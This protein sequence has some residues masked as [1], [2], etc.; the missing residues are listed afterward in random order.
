MG[1]KCFCH[2]N[3]LEVKDAK[4]RNAAITPQMFGYKSGDL[5]DYLLA[6][7][8]S[9]LTVHVPNGD[10]TITKEIQVPEAQEIIFDSNANV[11]L[12]G[13]GKFVLDRAS[14]LQGGR[15]LGSEVP[16]VMEMRSTTKW[17]QQA[18]IL[19][20]YIHG[21]KE[22]TNAIVINTTAPYV[23]ACYCVVD[24]VHISG[25][26]YGVIT[27]TGEWSNNHKIDVYCAET[28]TAIDLAGSG[29]MV[30]VA[31]Q[32]PTTE[33]V[34]VI[35]SGENNMVEVAIYDIRSAQYAVELTETSRY[36]IVTEFGYW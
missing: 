4:A 28:T 3:G 36:N 11:T 2:L 23:A 35:I 13:S 34:P 6:A 5:S 21:D 17:M 29:C 10:Y 7:I 19:N 12:S 16:V 30:R 33:S 1:D 14:K 32:A 9:G 31:G 25:C 20:C 22:S 24:N 18:K 26:R 15:F 8:S 27:K